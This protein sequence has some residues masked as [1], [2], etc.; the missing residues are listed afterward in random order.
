ME[1][2][3]EPGVQKEV[4][5]KKGWSLTPGFKALLI[6]CSICFMLGYIRTVARS[7]CNTYARI[8]Y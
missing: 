8:E 5:T 1:D 2:K 6:V 4:E 7:D 3:K